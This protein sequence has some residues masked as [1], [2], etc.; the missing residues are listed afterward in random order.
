VLTLH[1]LNLPICQANIFVNTAHI[2]NSFELVLNQPSNRWLCLSDQVHGDTAVGSALY[3]VSLPC[4]SRKV[5]QLC[6]PSIMRHYLTGPGSFYSWVTLLPSD[7]TWPGLWS[8]SS[9]LLHCQACVGYHFF[10]CPYLADPWMWAYLLPVDTSWGVLE[11]GQDLPHRWL[12]LA[13]PWMYPNWTSPSQCDTT[14]QVKPDWIYSLPVDTSWQ[15]NGDIHCWNHP[16]TWW[17]YLEGSWRYP[18]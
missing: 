4:K 13:G 17:S 15:V 11:A 14:W 18:K 7:S 12:H 9:S 5:L 6:Q 1:R 2:Q 8:W 16:S 10:R 3:K